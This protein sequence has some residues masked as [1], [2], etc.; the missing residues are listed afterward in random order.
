MSGRWVRRDSSSRF[1]RRDDVLIA[2]F[3]DG[4]AATRHRAAAVACARPS[5]H[6]D[7]T[8][9]P[10]YL[11]PQLV[12]AWQTAHCIA[13]GA[14][15]PVPDRGG[16]R[17]DTGSQ[18][19]TKRW[20]FPQLCDGLREVAREIAAPRHYLKL[21]GSDEELRS[22]LPTRW[23]LQPANY[24]MTA[25]TGTQALP[26]PDGYTVELYRAGPVARACVVAADGELA[27]SGYAAETADVFV[28]DRIETAPSHRR[29]GLG[30]AVMS[31]LGAAR[32]SRA[33][34]QLLVAS[35]DGRALYARLGWT[36]LAP[37]AAAVIADD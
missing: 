11:D 24:F 12:F 26:A 37:F 27:A 28:Y 19:E 21:C 20:V 1:A 15:S 36:V 33:N 7:S 5:A 3:A 25:A 10:S 14:P 6:D 35:E 17:V 18:K 34:P 8:M 16:V 13:R 30:A 22:A 29:K 31:A 23:T 32:K 2:S 9:T 4:A